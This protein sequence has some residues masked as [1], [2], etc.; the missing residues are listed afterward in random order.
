MTATRSL[1]EASIVD[2]ALRVISRDGVDSLSMRALSRELGVSAMA[3]YYYVKSK[4]E[5]LDL[6]AAQVLA[7]IAPP[8]SP[9]LEWPARLRL[10]IDQIESALR[11]HRG[12]G[13]LLLDRM[14]STQ[15]H[16]MRAIME[17]LSEAGFDDADVVMAYALIH[18]YLFGRYRVT[19][20]PL[21]T[22]SWP[23][24]TEP[25]GAEGALAEQ[26][27][28]IVARIRP[29]F[30]KLHGRDYY[31]FGIE[32]LIQGLEHQLAVRRGAG[33]AAA[34]AGEAQRQAATS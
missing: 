3:A 19:T 31:D 33:T 11:H 6:V 21:P 27:E 23:D 13:D 30:P 20:Q 9:G 26:D 28:D 4:E 2:A 5:L 22:P 18:T 32:T 24:G 15:R 10:L 25:A 12:L 8:A 29:L 1:T 14:H 7:D 17:L 16:V 34:S